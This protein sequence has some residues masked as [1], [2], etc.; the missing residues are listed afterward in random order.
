MKLINT[1]GMAFIGPGSEWFWTAVSGLVLAGTFIALYRQL[2]L[3]A[4]AMAT[5]QLTEFEREWSSERLLRM[6]LAVLLELQSGVDPA[7]LTDGAAHFV[8]DFW[9]RVGALV[10]GGRIDAKLIGKVNG[11][12]CEWWWAILKAYVIKARGHL[13]PTFGESFEWLS[14]VMSEFNRES[15][16]DWFDKI[17]DVTPDIAT[18]EWLIRVEEGLRS[19]PAPSSPAPRRQ[20]AP[21]RATPRRAAGSPSAT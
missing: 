3:Q 18:L 8:F 5:E 17:G 11:G 15:G 19:A 21:R 9:E 13:G 2:R 1:D 6:Q 4:N 7:K 10:R 20:A 12:V 14:G 16:I